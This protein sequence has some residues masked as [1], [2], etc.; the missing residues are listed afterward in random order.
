[1]NRLLIGS[2]TWDWPDYLKLDA[3]PTAPADIHCLFPPLPDTVLAQHFSEILMVHTIE[4]I[5]PW[6]V[7]E[8]L[9]E[10]YDILE[11]EG[12]FILEQPNILYAARVLLGLVEPPVYTGQYDMWPLYGDP[13]HRDELMLHR[14]GYSP[15]T[16]RYALIQAG[17]K[18]TKVELCPAQYHI[19]VRDFR[20]E[21][22]K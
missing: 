17:F 19:P 8:L 1:M 7:P 3:S 10:C 16:L 22:R 4:H 5:L 12:V 6:L 21:A 9:S 13:T 18:P 14:W 20:I 11:P 15:D 2:G